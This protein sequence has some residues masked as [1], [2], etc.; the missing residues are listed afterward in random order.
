MSPSLLMVWTLTVS[1][2]PPVHCPSESTS[3]TLVISEKMIDMATRFYDSHAVELADRVVNQVIADLQ[4]RIGQQAAVVVAA[5]A[6]AGKSYLVET[7]VDEVRPDRTVAV[8]VPTN[9]QAFD[10]V[11]RIADRLDR[12][13]SR[14]RVMFLHASAVVPPN[15]LPAR[16]NVL[17]PSDADPNDVAVLVGTL[18]KLGDAY[19]RGN[20]AERGLL[21]IDEAY[22]ANSSQ[23]L[24]AGALASTHLL[25]GDPGQIDP[26]STLPDGDYWRGL[27]E[28][29]VQ[30]AVGVLLRNHPST[31]VRQLPITR[32]LAPSAAATAAAFY[33]RL[34]F[35]A[36]VRVGVRQLSLAPAV[37]GR[38]A[39]VVNAA[40][41]EAAATGWAYL[42]LPS[43]LSLP[44]DPETAGLAVDVVDWLLRRAPRVVCE[45]R[46]LEQSLQAERV[47]LAVSH[48]DQVSHL[49]TRLD[50]Q[51]FA[52]VPVDTANRLQGLEFDVVVAIH[53]LT[54]LA[55]PDA[56]HL[57]PGRTCVMLTRHRHACIVIG[58]ER[59]PDFLGGVPPATPAYLGW[60]PDP[61]LDGWNVHRAVYDTLLEHRHRAA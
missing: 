57:D 56:F 36:A 44:A 53:P 45:R 61:V 27:P 9:E 1:P 47:A 5:P 48:R 29:P 21:I 30:T 42:E 50:A 16:S 14:E 25:V 3:L 26:F 12:T 13:Q 37:G 15:D 7:V 55:E 43:G 54:G 31:V 28:D 60:D 11:R 35:S 51:G 40:L 59:D 20:L 39:R 41:D 22:Q 46:Q 4:A 8:A 6:G 24:R 23:Y 17:L 58:R 32:R 2:L 38:A 10:L 49:R 19:I 52:R 34:P 18:D 33:P